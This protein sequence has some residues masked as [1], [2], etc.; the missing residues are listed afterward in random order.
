MFRVLSFSHEY[1]DLEKGHRNSGEWFMLSEYSWRLDGTGPRWEGV[2]QTLFFF[3]F[4]SF[5]SFLFFFFNFPPLSFRC[6][7]MFN[8]STFTDWSSSIF[9]IFA[10]KSK[11]SAGLSLVLSLWCS[12]VLLHI[13]Q[14]AGGPQLWR[15]HGGNDVLPSPE[16]SLLF[17]AGLWGHVWQATDSSSGNCCIIASAKVGWARREGG[18]TGFLG[19][20]GTFSCL[21]S[22]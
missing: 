9:F 2:T 10:F 19:R 5:F 8:A 6:F 21:L 4:F 22:F 13:H 20:R 3:F 1:W 14:K 17:S 7:W 16:V 12:G 15:I 11:K 18:E